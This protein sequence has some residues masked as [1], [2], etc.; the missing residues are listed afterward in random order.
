MKRFI[1]LLFTIAAITVFAQPKI[2]TPTPLSPDDLATNLMPN[3]TISWSGVTGSGVIKYKLLVDEAANFSSPMV[4]MTEF[5]TG[6]QMANLHFNQMYYWK[7][8]AYDLATGDSS[9]WS[10][11][12]SFTTFEKVALSSPANNAVDQA[13]LVSLKWKSNLGAIQISGVNKYQYAISTDETFTSPVLGVVAGSIYLVSTAKLQYGGKY[14][15]KIRG[16]V[17]GD[18][19]VWSETWNFTVISKPKLSKPGNNTVGQMLDVELKWDAIAGSKKYEYEVSTDELFSDPLKYVTEDVA[20][21]A[22]G[23]T[24]ATKYWWRVRARHESD[25]SNWSDIWNLTIIGSPALLLPADNA[26]DQER[27]PTCTWTKMTGINRY[28][29][30][31]SPTNTFAELLFDG[32]SIGDTI[33]SFRIPILLDNNTKYYWRMRAWHGADSSAWSTRSFTTKMGIGINDPQN[34]GVQ[35]YPNP[36]KDRLFVKLTNAVNGIAR[37]KIV[38]L[39]GKTILNTEFDATSSNRSF[40]LSLAGIPNGI[41]LLKVE[42][43]HKMHITKVV[44]DQ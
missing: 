17:E 38:D 26:V 6:V 41:Y 31:V 15:W 11:T 5:E 12:R 37:V 10:P 42:V 39:I 28:E 8:K 1:T 13:A 9:Y 19:S 33:T 21:V 22:E 14:Y 23:L 16:I 18:T 3:A 35:V 36:A 25:T 2:Y 32:N 4:F 40:E 24:F 30:Q 34:M 43:N 20:V 27:Q 29:M 44:I 7:V